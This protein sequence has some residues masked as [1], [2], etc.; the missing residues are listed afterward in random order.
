MIPELRKENRNIK[1]ITPRGIVMPEEEQAAE[2][3]DEN[4][5]L[6]GKVNEDIHNEDLV[7]RFRIANSDFQLDMSA[8][9]LYKIDPDEAEKQGS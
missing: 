4:Q 3:A 1:K 8:D 6:S 7:I 5:G 2:L 9:E